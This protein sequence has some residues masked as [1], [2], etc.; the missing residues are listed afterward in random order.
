MLY[1]IV[2]DIFIYCTIRYPIA[3]IGNHPKPSVAI[4]W[5]S[6]LFKKRNISS[7]FSLPYRMIY[8]A[9]TQDSVYIYDTQQ[10]RPIC[11]ISGMHFA[12]ITDLTW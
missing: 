7:M 4:R 10:S 1:A 2:H 11:A 5:C 9:A 8:A 6:M 3:S 12:P